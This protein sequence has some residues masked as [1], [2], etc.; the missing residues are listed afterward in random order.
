MKLVLE[1]EDLRP[2]YHTH[3]PDGVQFHMLTETAKKFVR[4]LGSATFEGRELNAP[5]SV[6]YWDFIVYGGYSEH[7][8]EIDTPDAEIAVKQAKELIADL[9]K[10]SGPLYGR[11]N[12]AR[13]GLI[14][15][16]RGKVSYWRSWGLDGS[17]Q[18]AA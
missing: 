10:R 13:Y 7:F 1:P 18:K 4:E 15:V 5:F 17:V 3:A 8:R 2:Q 6:R 12:K 16:I 9:N 11:M 14:E